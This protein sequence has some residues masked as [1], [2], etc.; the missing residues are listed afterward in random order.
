MPRLNEGQF[1][2]EGRDPQEELGPSEGEVALESTK[3]A[4]LSEEE[5][6][7]IM[8]KV[9]DINDYGTAYHVIT[10]SEDF[11][12]SIEGRQ[13]IRSWNERLKDVFRDGLL[14]TIHERLGMASKIDREKWAKGVRDEK[15]GE[16]MFNIVGREFRDTEAGQM[17]LEEALRKGGTW[18]EMGTQMWQDS[19]KVAV[20]LDLSSFQ[21][22]EPRKDSENF[23]LPTTKTFHIDSLNIKTNEKGELMAESSFGFALYPRVAP[24]LFKGLVFKAARNYTN[25]EVE[26]HLKVWGDTPERRRA[27]EN[28]KTEEADPQKLQERADEIV[29]LMREVC[30]DRLDLLVPVYDVRGNLYWPEELSHE[31]I[32]KK[33]K[34]TVRKASRVVLH[35]AVK[36]KKSLFETLTTENADRIARILQ[37]KPIFFEN[38]ETPEPKIIL[39]EKIAKALPPEFFENPTAWIESQQNIARGYEMPPGNTI[40]E[41]WES[42]YDVSKV[43]EF[44]VVLSD[45][46]VVKVV[47]KR[48]KPKE[49]EEIALATKAYS[50]GIPTPK[51]LA[52]VFDRG[53]SYAFFEKLEA[54]DLTA[55][56]RKRKMDQV[57]IFTGGSVIPTFFACVDEGKFQNEVK[58]WPYFEFLSD[59]ARERIHNLWGK[60][61]DAIVTREANLTL[62]NLFRDLSEIENGRWDYSHIYESILYQIE[63]LDGYKKD[64]IARIIGKYGYKNFRNFKDEIMQSIGSKQAYYE[65]LKERVRSLEN[66]DIRMSYAHRDKLQ[67][68]IFQDI[69]G[70][71]LVKEK[72]KLEQLCRNKGIEHKDFANRNILINWDF[73]KD[74]PKREGKKKPKL[75]IVDWESRSK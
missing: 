56:F 34:E 70:C 3:E 47:S 35:A 15:R 14:G 23:A 46:V 45:G 41:L 67:S 69:F 16:V 31:E 10:P 9:Q 22:V 43:K 27:Y 74:Q 24:R 4:E 51:V 55:A 2:G 53:N 30:K 5:I 33:S 12:T 54:I 7:R 72:E 29:A 21:E 65:S 32:E 19:D 75:Y 66:E 64:V 36:D 48:I 71:D 26:Q 63:V 28:A 6:E 20:I 25:E 57:N 39:D 8:D 1:G 68:I 62:G 59:R 73:K 37:E 38:K 13:D 49:I 17:E 50:V 40:E 61:L 52:E 60:S 44:E 11:P 18:I 58:N 42:P